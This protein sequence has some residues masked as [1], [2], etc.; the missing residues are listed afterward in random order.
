MRSVNPILSWLAF[1]CVLL[2][3]CSRQKASSAGPTSSAQPEVPYFQV[4]AASAGSVDGTI[5]FVGAKPPAK[6]V[7]MS[8]DPACVQAHRGKPYED[9]LIVGPRGGIAN[10]FLYVEKGLEGKR[11]AVPSSPVVINQTGCW[12]VPRV[13]GIQVGQPL[14][15]VN[16]DP[17][18]HNIH[19][20][21]SIN[22]EWNH[23]QGPGDPPI[24]RHFTQPEIMIPIKC[25]IHSWMRAY[26]GVVSNPYYAVSGSSGDFK[27]SNLPPGTYT[28]AA[29]QEQFGTERQTVTV[30]PGGA[31]HVQFVFR[32]R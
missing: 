5:R 28:I 32:A 21:A 2:A 9:A 1:W 6:P 26:I 25:N 4:D 24:V 10:V 8:S 17:V 23:S 13:L 30:G 14:Q 19:P 18:T 15:V 16:S 27:I 20:M 12:F 22:R 7:D 3:G 11:F 29:W 31:V